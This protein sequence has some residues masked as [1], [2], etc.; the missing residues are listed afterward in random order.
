MQHPKFVLP[1]GPEGTPKVYTFWKG[2]VALYAILKALDIGSG[3]RVLLPGYT[4]MVV[5]SAVMFAGA[6]PLYADV[7]AAS[8]NVT[9]GTLEA[10]LQ[11]CP[12]PRPK[13][14][15][16]QHTYGIPVEAAPIIEWARSEGMPVIEDCAHVMGSS[17]HG[18]PCGSLGDAAFFSSQWNKPITTGLGGWAVANNQ[19]LAQRLSLVRG[20]FKNPGL[21]EVRKLRLLVAAHQRLLRPKLYWQLMGLYRWL[22]HLGL[23]TGSSEK[24]E[25]RNEMPRRYAL[26]MSRFQER[27]LA[28]RMVETETIPRGRRRL[29]ALY[30]RELADAGISLP[31]IPPNSSAVFLRYPILVRN[32]R[33]FLQKARERRLEV[34]DWFVSPLHP[35]EDNWEQFGYRQ[36]TCPV[37]EALC[38]RV[39]NLPTLTGNSHGEALSIIRDLLD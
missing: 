6:Q 29:A 17:Y 25:F 22:S 32:K 12:P 37:A 14:V 2:R 30:E 31:R 3:D 11:K 34:G 33:D 8:Y 35:L 38:E 7:E 13:A 1:A 9:L 26:T 16:I 39:V 4:C 10:A 20:S 23:V 21:S 27:L 28:R 19:V 5:P 15:I 18:V 36:G 24:D